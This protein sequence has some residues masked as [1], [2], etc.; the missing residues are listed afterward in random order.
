MKKIISHVPVPIAG[1]SLGLA[2]LGNLVQEYT[3]SLRYV[4][5]GIAFLLLAMLLVR[6]LIF[7]K[8][9]KKEFENPLIFSVSG[10]IYMTLMQLSGYI[11]PALPVFATIVWLASIL[12]HLTLIVLFTKKF[13]FPL[14]IKNIYASCFVTY[15]GIIVGSVTS[16]TFQMQWLGEILF[17]FGF[18][19]Y[20]FIFVL[21]TF[22]YRKH[23]DSIAD[24]AKPVFCIYAAPMSLSI[25]GYMG[26]FTNPNL[27]FLIV[28]EVIAHGLLIIVLIQLKK[29]LKLTF[30][31]SYAAFTFPFVISAFA[32]TKVLNYAQQMNHTTYPL[33][34]G[35]QIIEM[36]FAS[37]MVLY[38]LIRYI[39]YL[40]SFI[41]I[42]KKVLF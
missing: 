26:A 23:Y 19:C 34:K 6:C 28:L 11:Y 31:P 35:I 12:A 41:S 37:F 9:V 10:T 17:Y 27:T 16:A 39:M 5:G 25:A 13:L 30:Y 3:E 8:D 22:R 21:I 42:K 1:L 33:I 40:T 15:V 20:F 24:M 4:C 36:V 38:T 7:F 14:N 32:T 29:F 2:A 18:I